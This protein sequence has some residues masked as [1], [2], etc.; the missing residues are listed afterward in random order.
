MRST[1]TKSHCPFSPLP[2]NKLGRYTTLDFFNPVTPS[3]ITTS[4]ILKSPEVRFLIVWSNLNHFPV[5]QPAATNSMHL[6]STHTPHSQHLQSDLSQSK[7]CVGAFLIKQS[8]C[9]GCWLFSQRRSI[10][11]IWWS[12]KCSSIWG[13]AF[14][15][16]GYRGEF[17]TPPAS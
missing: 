5:Q 17:W 10:V 12:S 15:H 16:W 1:R 7:V 6:Q 9:E 4:G 14:H 11:D 3:Q 13:E 2:S 8:T